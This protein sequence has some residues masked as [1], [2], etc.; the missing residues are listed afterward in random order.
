MKRLLHLSASP[1]GQRSLSERL[2]E[3]FLAEVLAVNPDVAVERL[4]VFEADLPAFGKVEAEAK[5]APFTGDPVTPAHHLAWTRITQVVDHFKSFDSV[6]LSCPM[7]NYSIPWRL[8]LYFDCLIQPGLT[9]G[10]DP[11]RMVHIGLLPNVP[12]QFLLTRSSTFPGDHSDFQLPYLRFLFSGMG[13]ND[14]RVL[15]AWR[16][17]QATPQAR[18]AYETG[19]LA[20]AKSAGSI[21]IS[22]R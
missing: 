14:V 15:T 2:A 9:F 11:E 19:V 16:S 12:T 13:I 1:K 5:F 21:F 6:V 4:N 3:V 7:W 17:T 10:Y 18:E 20:E 22:A 8:K